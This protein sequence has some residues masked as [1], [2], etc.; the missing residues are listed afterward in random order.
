M[1]NLAENHGMNLPFKQIFKKDLVKV[2]PLVQQW[3]DFKNSPELFTAR[4][5][6]MFK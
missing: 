1:I 3:S 6:E 2:I 4:F 5:T